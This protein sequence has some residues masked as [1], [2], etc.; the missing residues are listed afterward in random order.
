[1]RKKKPLYGETILKIDSPTR[2]Q[3]KKSLDHHFDEK[4][5]IYLPEGY[6]QKCPGCGGELWKKGREEYFGEF[7]CQECVDKWKQG[8]K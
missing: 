8:H 1:M 6:D 4:R 3:I 7:F 5:K 2:S